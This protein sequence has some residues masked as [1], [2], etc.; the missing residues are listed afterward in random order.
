MQI[1]LTKNLVWLSL[2]VG[3]TIA[4]AG[5][6][7]LAAN[8]NPLITPVDPAQSTTL[9]QRIA[10][11]KASLKIQV[12]K[13]RQQV[14]KA[15]CS[16]AQ[17]ALQSQK[18]GDAIAADSRRQVYTDLATRL[19]DLIA[20]LKASNVD[21]TSLAAVQK[22]FNDAIN[23]YLTDAA[24]YKTT[25]DDVVVIGC[26]NDPAG[27]ET[28]LEEARRLRTQLAADVAKIKAL[29]PALVKA[30]NDARQTLMKAN[31]VE[32]EATQ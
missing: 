25:M 6:A 16:T 10:Q 19:N 13:A 27:F 30:I 18:N 3:L 5:G 24:A 8:D 22:Q 15:K 17:G 7:A 23:T 14:I 9:E 26:V 4:V 2:F 32:Q 20:K 21:T 1:K 29:R 28:N 31:A 11:R 12:S